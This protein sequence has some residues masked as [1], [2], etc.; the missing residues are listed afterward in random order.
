MQRP[1]GVRTPAPRPAKAGGG[2]PMGALIKYVVSL[3][4]ALA[5]G[6]SAASSARAD[7]RVALVI[8]N[9]QYQHAGILPKAV[10]DANAIADLLR[11]VGFDEVDQRSDLG[12]DGFRQAVQ[13]FIQLSLNA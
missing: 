13:Q 1:T 12:V 9:A 11:K 3:S 2:D 10:N 8:G 4:L 5:I 6:L 7:P